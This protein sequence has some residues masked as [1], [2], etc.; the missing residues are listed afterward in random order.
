M[1]LAHKHNLQKGAMS[2]FQTITL[3]IFGLFVI[4]G[5]LALSGILPIFKGDDSGIPGVSGTV[6][7]WGIF[8]EEYFK[9]P[10]EELNRKNSK[11]YQIDYVEKQSNMFDRELVEA[12][13]SGRG[14]DIIL[15]PQDLIVRHTDKIYLIPY[16]N[17]SERTFKDT[18]VDEGE[19]FLRPEGIVALPVTIDPMVLY[20]NRDLFN[21]AGIAT[22][23]RFWDEFYTISPR[24]TVKDSQSNISRSVVALGEFRNVTH[25]KEI[26]A[27]L[28]FQ[29]GNPITQT[30]EGRISTLLQERFG[31]ATSPAESALR[32]FTE[33]SNPV[34]PF[35]SW[36]RALPPAKDYFLG[37]DLAVYIGFSSELAEIK[38]KS[39]HLNFDV[40]EIPQVR[41][42]ASKITFGNMLGFAVLKQSDNIS[43]AF[44]GVF[45]M[46]QKEFARSFSKQ[47]DL[48]PARRDV[49]SEK[50]AN[51]FLE[52]FYRSALIA[53]AWF[54]PD[55]D[56]T[57][58]IFRD[59]VENVVSGRVKV[60]DAVSRAHAE[61]N[62]VFEQLYPR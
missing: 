23:P 55:P 44:Q 39:P 27:T 51:S 49:L 46:T 35:Y 9:K 21:S 8:P 59:M 25:A 38:E 3:G 14:P 13:A 4:I 62:T 16:K 11:I 40:A 19:L 58:R 50:P 41:D 1:Q 7:I 12:L 57:D 60:R 15:L 10:L 5:F 45:D 48:P 28:I 42:A 34:K 47:S 56:L 6:T 37:G 31:F 52:T 32:F 54:D 29:A 18:F 61:L 20:W 2:L 30:K 53:R 22:P 43:T 36:N 26:I 24:I 33:F 17:I